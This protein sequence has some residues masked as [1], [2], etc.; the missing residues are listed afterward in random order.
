MK[1]QNLPIEFMKMHGLGNDFVVIDTRGRPLPVGSIVAET[2]SD[3]RFGIGYDQLV[4]IEESDVAHARLVFF[5]SDGSPSATCG[6]ATRCLGRYFMDQENI[7]MV[8]LETDGGILDCHEAGN[9]LSRVNMGIPLLEW[10]EI[11]LAEEMNTLELPIEGNPCA[12]GMGNPHCV[13]F[14]DNAE[15]VDL[16]DIGPRIEHH[17]LFPK[18]TNVEFVSIRS[19]SEIRVRIWERGAG[20]TLASG[21]G[22]CAAVIASI[23]RGLTSS[24]VEVQADGGCLN[25]EW[26]DDGVLMTGPTS[27]VFNGTLSREFQ[28]NIL[29]S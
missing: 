9:G 12:V 24:K 26:S 4:L 19:Q 21:S 16:A 6:N 18:R 27:H 28:E 13:F 7:P 25:I 8:Q 1:N 29:A 10:H 15:A 22:T 2:L 5:N 17:P 20:I 23:R 3:R 11:P 14:V